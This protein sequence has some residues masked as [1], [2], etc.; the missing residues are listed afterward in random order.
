MVQGEEPKQLKP[1]T[2]GCGGKADSM[3]TCSQEQSSVCS[4]QQRC[5]DPGVQGA[6]MEGSSTR[7]AKGVKPRQTLRTAHHH[8]QVSGHSDHLPAD[9]EANKVKADCGLIYT[10]DV[11][12]LLNAP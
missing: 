6:G 1:S 3:D 7:F 5:I 9:V 10:L 4:F 2:E 8:Q 11:A 12:T